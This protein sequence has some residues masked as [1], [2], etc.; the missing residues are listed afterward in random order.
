VQSF[1]FHVTH[2]PL[3]HLRPVLKKWYDINV[4]YCNALGDDAM[5]WYTE[6]ANVGAL[7]AAVWRCGA[8][9]LEEFSARRGFGRHRRQGRADLWFRWRGT[10][11]VIEAKREWVCL[12]PRARDSVKRVSLALKKAKKAAVES[13]YQ[14]KRRLGVVFAV[15]YI[16]AKHADQ[17]H[18]LVREFLGDLRKKA[19]YCVMCS[20]FPPA[21]RALLAKHA[22]HPGVVLLARM[23]KRG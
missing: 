20:V 8:P 11:Y 7:A 1:N 14:G 12:S 5:Y 17:S 3:A 16:P 15:P 18:R 23:T 13:R 4:E 2:G 10:D 21:A 19:R 22:F 6:R 9:A